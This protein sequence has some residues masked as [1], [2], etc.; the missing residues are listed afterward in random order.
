MTN[1]TTYQFNIIP[2]TSDLILNRM[3]LLY[4]IIINK[5]KNALKLK[6]LISHL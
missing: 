2:R 1:P 6:P 5:N 4:C 3:I